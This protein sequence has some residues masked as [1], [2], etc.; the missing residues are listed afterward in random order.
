M[1]MIE[2]FGIGG[3]RQLSSTHFTCASCTATYNT[4]ILNSVSD[5]ISHVQ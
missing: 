3:L 4:W 5:W 1:P 2:V